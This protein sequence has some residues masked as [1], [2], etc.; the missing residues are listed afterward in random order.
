M[1]IETK[2]KA[3]KDLTVK[4]GFPK[5]NSETNSQEDGVTALEK[6]VW[7]N[8]GL[9]VPERPF[10]DIAYFKNLNKYKKIIV[11]K[12]RNLEKFDQIKFL[13]ELGTEAVNDIQGAI[14]DLKDPPNDDKTIELKGS[15]NPL[16]DSGH[17]LQSVTYTVQKVK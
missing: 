4:V 14:I 3:F 11:K 17:M 15:S 5:E 1:N 2:V 8:F 16:F 13:N 9:G 7:N 10:M 6:A 12:S